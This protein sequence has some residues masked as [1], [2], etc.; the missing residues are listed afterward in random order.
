[1]QGWFFS[2][3][4]ASTVGYGDYVPQT[5]EGQIFVII[6]AIVAIPVAGLC[7]VILSSRVVVRYGEGGGGVEVIIVYEQTLCSSL[8]HQ[9][10]AFMP[11]GWSPPFL[12]HPH[13]FSGID[14]FSYFT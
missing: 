9:S 4:I 6:Y 10:C 1:M 13:P 11:L 2:L 5:P 7:M 12:A 8:H 3:T 14:C